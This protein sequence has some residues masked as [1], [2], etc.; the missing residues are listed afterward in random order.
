MVFD[1]A[2]EGNKPVLNHRYSFN[3]GITAAIRQMNLDY[4]GNLIVTGDNVVRVYA[5]PRMGNTT[6]TPAKRALVVSKGEI[7]AVEPTL[8]TMPVFTPAACEYRESIEVS[9]ACETP[10]T[11]LFYTI[12]EGENVSAEKRYTAPFSLKTTATVTAY[13]RLLN[14][15]GGIL[16][17]SDGNAYESAATAIYTLRKVV[18][19]PVI[20]P[21]AGEY[22]DSIQVSMTCATEGAAIYYTI[23]GGAETLYAAPFTLKYQNAT[24]AAY[25]VLVDAE[26]NR[27]VDSYGVEYRSENN[28]T[29]TYIHNIVVPNPTFSP[30]A[31]EYEDEVVVTLS[32]DRQNAIILYGVIPGDVILNYAASDEEFYFGDELYTEPIKLTETSTVIAVAVATDAAGNIVKVNDLPAFASEQVYAKYIITQKG[33]GVDDTQLAAVVYSTNGAIHVQAEAG[34]MIELFTVQG[35]C[36]YAA[37][38]TTNLTTIEVPTNIVL[39]RVAGQTVKVAVK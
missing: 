27:L 21:V 13:A 31:G 37:E 14:H 29:A 9:I 38:A 22:S 10:N 15:N 25:A 19:A 3:H 26:G 6:I 16:S 39:V 18:A 24:V 23:N 32:C 35:Q 36:L 7:V 34:T 8:P 2:W 5:M 33:V 1:I 20:A 4:A 28:P 30:K 17:N 11:V 12:T